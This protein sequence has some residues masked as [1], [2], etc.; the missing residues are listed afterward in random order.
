MAANP[1]VSYYRKRALESLTPEERRQ[2]TEGQRYGGRGLGLVAT[3][4]FPGLKKKLRDIDNET[5]EDLT[6]GDP[7]GTPEQ[8]AAQTLAR[9]QRLAAG[10]GRGGGPPDIAEAVEA[11]AA[12]FERKRRGMGRTRASSFLG[13]GPSFLGGI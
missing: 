4:F 5:L 11:G 12:A 1:Y 9:R 3:T 8:A 7:G 13:G 6:R 2:A 10:Q